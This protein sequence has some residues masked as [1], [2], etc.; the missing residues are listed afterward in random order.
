VSTPCSLGPC[1]ALGAP[2]LRV[3]FGS[4]VR[5][6]ILRLKHPVGPAARFLRHRVPFSRPASG[7]KFAINSLAIT[8]DGCAVGG[9]GKDSLDYRWFMTEDAM[10]AETL[11]GLL[12]EMVD[13]KIQHYAESN[14]K[15]SPELTRI[16]FEKRE[17][18][19]RRLN[20]IRAELVRFLES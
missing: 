4:A 9:A 6:P 3:P 18:D 1:Q 19:R 14:L 15:L 7:L 12:E 17:T 11:I 2:L 16:L 20:Q 5:K 13:L 10:T 8:P